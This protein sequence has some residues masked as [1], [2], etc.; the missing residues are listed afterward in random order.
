MACTDLISIDDQELAKLNAAAFTEFME[1]TEDTFDTPG[2]LTKH[3]LSGALVDVDDAIDDINADVAIVDAAK[4][5][6]LIQIDADLAT[7]AVEVNTINDSVAAAAASEDAASDFADDSED[8]ATDSAASAALA[9]SIANFVGLW[10]DQTGAANVPYSVYHDGNYWSLL[11][12]VA[13]V[14][15]SEPSMSNSEWAIAYTVIENIEWDVD[16]PFNDGIKIVKGY[17]TY[18]TLDVSDAQD[19]SVVIDLPTRSCDF[20]RASGAGNINKSGVSVTLLDD[21]PAITS[22]GI[23]VFGSATNRILYSKDLTQ[24]GWTG[25]A[26]KVYNYI[27]KNGVVFNKVTATDNTTDSTC[28]AGLSNLTAST[29]YYISFIVNVDES[30]SAG[31]RVTARDFEGTYQGAYIDFV[32]DSNLSSSNLVYEGRQLICEG[33]YK[34]EF[35][36]EADA[37]SASVNIQS[38]TSLGLATVGQYL[39]FSNVMV[40]T[41]KNYPHIETNG[42]QESAADT[43]VS[44][45]YQNNMPAFGSDFTIIVDADGFTEDIGEYVVSAYNGSEYNVLIRHRGSDNRLDFRVSDGYIRSSVLTLDSVGKIR[46]AFTMKDAALSFYADGSNIDVVFSTPIT[47][48]DIDIASE[49]FIGSDDGND[50]FLNGTLKN[51]KILHRA[52]TAAEVAALGSAE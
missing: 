22:D 23:S 9:S 15:L 11:S 48:F 2:G 26:T 39:V 1:S 44:I 24:S 20:S 14:T 3:T 18:D 36:I 50:D 5:A 4:D 10:S 41:I 32:T 51:L 6:A 29:R 19:E 16:I 42:T 46:L 17:G 33:V 47:T 25:N 31:V 28:V 8:S 49:V 35:S 40:T 45:P 30:D 13:D 34:Y 43:P 37:T 52:L 27:T 38:Y 12:N 7:V 21:E